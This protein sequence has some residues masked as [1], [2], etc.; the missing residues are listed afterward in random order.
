MVQQA[1]KAKS[2]TDAGAKLSDV[3]ELGVP[4]GWTSDKKDPLYLGN[5]SPLTVAFG[6]LLTVAAIMLGAPFWFD[7]LGR[8]SRL[9][10]TGKPEAPLPATAFGKPGERVVTDARPVAVTVQA[11][12]PPPTTEAAR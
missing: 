6:W 12:A 7:A 10:G 11:V 5:Q 9:R 4:L 1:G 3:K 8:L 2:P